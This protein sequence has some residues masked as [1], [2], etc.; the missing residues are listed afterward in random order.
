MRGIDHS[1]LHQARKLVTGADVHR[2]K[3]WIFCYEISEPG[4]SHRKRYEKLLRKFVNT[5][6]LSFSVRLRH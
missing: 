1:L 4:S 2:L 5:T 6:N 3:T